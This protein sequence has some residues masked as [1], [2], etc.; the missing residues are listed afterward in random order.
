MRSPSSV[1]PDIQLL[2]Y[3]SCAHLSD[4]QVQFMRS[5]SVLTSKYCSSCVQTSKYSRCNSRAH[6][7]RSVLT[8]KY[9]STAHVVHSK[10]SRC[11]SRGHLLRSVLTSKN[12]RCSMRSPSL[13]CSHI[14]KL[15]TQFTCSPSWSVLTSKYSSCRSCA[16]LL[17][18]VLTSECS[19]RPHL[20]RSVLTSKYSRCSSCAFA[21]NQPT[22]PPTNTM[23]HAQTLVH[24]LLFGE[25]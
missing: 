25:R 19:S 24:I 11:S 21:Q 5:W 16:H 17:R 20:L 6:L 2:K 1:C 9:S 18:T 14:Q 7:L 8:S 3:S 23:L 10:Y 22:H 15:Q 13:V 4:A 12:S